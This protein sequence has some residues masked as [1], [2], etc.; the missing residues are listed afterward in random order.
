MLDDSA[1]VRGTS[2]RQTPRL[3]VA[4]QGDARIARSFARHIDEFVLQIHGIVFNV[5]PTGNGR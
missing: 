1:R 2:P 3:E 5:L 4:L